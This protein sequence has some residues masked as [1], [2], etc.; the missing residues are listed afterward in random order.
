[1]FLSNQLCTC[2][3]PLLL[4]WALFSSLL[5]NHLCMASEGSSLELITLATLPNLIQSWYQT[6]ASKGS[7]LGSLGTANHSAVMNGVV[8]NP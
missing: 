8:N 2:L 5:L 7:L 6:G 1:M 4:L 3:I